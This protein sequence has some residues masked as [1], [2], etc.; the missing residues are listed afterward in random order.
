MSFI[1]ELTELGAKVIKQGAIGYD[2][3]ENLKRKLKRKWEEYGGG[4]EQAR[5]SCSE[6]EFFLYWKFHLDESYDPCRPTAEQVREALP[7][8]LKNVN[9]SNSY[10]EVRVTANTSRQPIEYI[11]CY[12]Y[13]SEVN[14]LVEK[15]EQE[16]KEKKRERDEEA[17]EESADN[18]KTEKKPKT[19]DP[20]EAVK[21]EVPSE[22]VKEEEPPTEEAPPKPSPPALTRCATIA[23]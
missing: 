3:T 5:K 19:E 13:E 16:A 14:T 8:E 6:R 11:V 23:A 20:S 7:D 12:N 17:T 4:K 22:A 2:D 10:D 9:K 1:D 18:V 15:Q 21:E